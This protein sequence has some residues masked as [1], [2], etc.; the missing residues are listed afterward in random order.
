MVRHSASTGARP[1]LRG[2]SASSAPRCL[3]AGS[4]SA[5]PNPSREA[6]QTLLLAPIAHK[7]AAR[8][9]QTA[10]G[11]LQRHHETSMQR[12]AAFE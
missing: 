9:G 6:S 2:S 10:K 12:N 11:V 4:Q 5:P 1:C 3:S 8:V 7:T